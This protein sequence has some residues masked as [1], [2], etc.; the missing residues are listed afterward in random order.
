VEH[1]QKIK[2]AKEQEKMRGGWGRGPWN[3]CEIFSKEAILVYRILVYPLIG[4]QSSVVDALFPSLPLFFPALS[5]TLFF[6]R[7]PLFE[8]LQQASSVGVLSFQ[9]L[10]LVF[11]IIN[12]RVHTL[13]SKA[14]E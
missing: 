1:E 5:L 2:Q 14:L 8:C 3:A 12:Q 4:Q 13:H 10:K 7:A 6:A 9:T 11:C